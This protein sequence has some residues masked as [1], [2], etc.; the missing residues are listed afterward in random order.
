MLRGFGHFDQAPLVVI[1]GCVSWL[2]QVLQFAEQQI[3]EHAW[4][5]NYKKTM[6]KYSCFG[7][8]ENPSKT[9]RMII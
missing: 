9:I 3:V 5:E 2:S 1:S 6:S 7:Q 8:Q 4:E